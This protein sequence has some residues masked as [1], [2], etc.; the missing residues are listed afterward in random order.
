MT[1]RSATEAERA[2]LTGA[3]WTVDAQGWWFSA[4]LGAGRTTPEA[5]QIVRRR[6]ALAKK[7]ERGE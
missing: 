4:Q 3:G 5:L 2:E 6:K 1:R 7:R